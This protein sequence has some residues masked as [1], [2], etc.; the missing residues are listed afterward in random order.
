MTKYLL[1]IYNSECYREN[2]ITFFCGNNDMCNAY[3]VGN[4]RARNGNGQ[5]VMSEPSHYNKWR[6]CVV[7]CRVHLK[8][9]FK[10]EMFLEI[11][12]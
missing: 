7:Y 11:Y 1:F 9:Q 10:E 3:K 6:E 2:A 5:E 12:S 8:S 4:K